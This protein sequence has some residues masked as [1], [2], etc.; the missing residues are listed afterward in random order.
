[1]LNTVLVT[2]ED[3]QSKEALPLFKRLISSPSGT[4]RA[5]QVKQIEMILYSSNFP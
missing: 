3:T 5:K 2:L 4:D 1:M